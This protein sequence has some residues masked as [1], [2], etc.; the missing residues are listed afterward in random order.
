M[1]QE[2]LAWFRIG[3]KSRRYRRGVFAREQRAGTLNRN[4]PESELCACHVSGK[5]LFVPFSLPLSFS[6]LLSKVNVELS[7]AREVVGVPGNFEQRLYS[8]TISRPPG[9]TT[10]CSG[11]KGTCQTRSQRTIYQPRS[12]VILPGPKLPP[13][14]CLLFGSQRAHRVQPQL[15][16]G[17]EPPTSSGTA[18]H[19]RELYCCGSMEPMWIDQLTIPLLC[20]SIK[21]VVTRC[22][23]WRR[24]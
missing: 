10:R 17:K 8:A 21:F 5:L 24:S 14:R 22:Y 19:L 1:V 3:I 20:D 6:R 4:S 11:S 15:Q 2:V 18:F 23:R 12:D 16:N 13:L 9:E 7:F